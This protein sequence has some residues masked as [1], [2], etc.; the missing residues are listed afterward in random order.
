MVNN[1]GPLRMVGRARERDEL[2]GAWSRQAAG[3]SGRTAVVTGDAGIGKSL[4]VATALDAF[5]PR[6]RVVLAGTARVHT[7]APYDWLAA[8]LSGRDTADLPVPADALG[9]LAQDPDVPIHRYAPT[10]LL[11]IA[12]R[13]VRSLVG[14]G[15]AVLVVEDLHALDPAS[16]NL[17]GEV[18]TSHDLPA[19]MLVTSQPPDAADSPQLAARTL[20]RLGGAPGAIRQHLGPLDDAGVGAILAQLYPDAAVPDDLVAAALARTQGNPYRLTELVATA[21]SAGSEAL[22]RQLL[23]S[24]GAE[25][26]ARELEVLA[27]LAEGMSNKQVARSLNISI[28]TVAVHVS[29]LL[30]KTRL[31]SRTEVALWA[32]QH[33]GAVRVRTPHPGV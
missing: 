9:W 17:I 8:V 10:T 25:L 2:V 13:V 16:L 23:N 5:D 20:A 32:V 6:P 19:L 14:E 12:V 7:P 21:G 1:V 4:L 33:P 18:A 28:R 15:P 24:S 30:R 27:C 11:R 3:G 29:N 22:A 31:T 26:T